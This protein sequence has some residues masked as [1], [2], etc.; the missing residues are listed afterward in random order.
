MPHTM[1]ATKAACCI[2]LYRSWA[3]TAYNT[4]TACNKCFALCVVWSDTAAHGRLLVVSVSVAVISHNL[5]PL[6]SVAVH[7]ATLWPIAVHCGN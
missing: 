6:Q 5:S 1:T 2:E 4:A 7:C 3:T